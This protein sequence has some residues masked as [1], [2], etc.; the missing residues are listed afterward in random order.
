MRLKDLGVA[1]TGLS[2]AKRP[3]R[4]KLISSVCVGYNWLQSNGDSAKAIAMHINQ[5]MG[6]FNQSGAVAH[7]SERVI[8]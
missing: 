3:I 4:L 5:V 1:V 8:T 7:L 2:D 6:E